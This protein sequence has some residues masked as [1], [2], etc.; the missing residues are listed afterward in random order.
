MMCMLSYVNV[1]L[2]YRSLLKI[3]GIPIIWD[4]WNYRELLWKIKPVIALKKKIYLLFERK[5][6]GE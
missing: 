1:I 4:I 3:V 2:E 5:R 6:K